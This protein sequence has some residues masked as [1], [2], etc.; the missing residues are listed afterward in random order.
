MNIIGGV[1]V[2]RTHHA[3]VLWLAHPESP[4]FFAPTQ[5]APKESKTIGHRTCVNTPLSHNQEGKK[6]NYSGACA[7][8]ETGLFM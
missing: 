5:I 4:N 2:Q 6:I 8:C 1:H 7:Q 3:L